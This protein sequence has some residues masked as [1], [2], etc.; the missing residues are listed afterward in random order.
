[1]KY[2]TDRPFADPEKAARKLRSPARSSRS[3]TGQH[4]NFDIY[5]L[6]FGTYEEEHDGLTILPRNLAPPQGRLQ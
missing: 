6:F 2:A 5:C 1:M 3:R 4:R